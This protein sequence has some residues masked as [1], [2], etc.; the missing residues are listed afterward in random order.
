MVDQFFRVCR[1]LYKAPF[2]KIRVKRPYFSIEKIPIERRNDFIPFI[3]I[4]I[5]RGI[6]QQGM[7]RRDAQVASSL[8]NT[9]AQTD[10][11][12]SFSILLPFM[13]ISVPVFSVSFSVRRHHNSI[14]AM[15]KSSRPALF[16]QA[17]RKSTY[18][19][20]YG[21]PERSL[22]PPAGSQS[23]QNHI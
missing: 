17:K 22:P 14:P 11:I 15:T 1:Y 23:K 12:P 21:T 3:V 13:V 5:F 20:S 4:I 9:P 2:P 18:F 7:Y 6:L 8:S 19:C 16:H 10:T